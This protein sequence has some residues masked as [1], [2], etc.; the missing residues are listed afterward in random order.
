MHPR[1]KEKPQQGGRRGKIM[2]RIKPHTRQRCSEGANKPCVHQDPE[3]TQRLRQNYVC[4]S[5]RGTGQQWTAS[6]T[7]ALAAADLGMA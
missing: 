3:T 7:G 2:F 5:Y 1:A 4:V 6:G